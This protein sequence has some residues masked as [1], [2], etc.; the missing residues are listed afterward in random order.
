MPSAAIKTAIQCRKE[1]EGK[2]QALDYSVKQA[3]CKKAG[4]KATGGDGELV[5]RLMAL[6]DAETVVEAESLRQQL[7]EVLVALEAKTNE[8]EKLYQLQ[9]DTRVALEAKTKEAEK[10][11]QRLT[12]VRAAL[13]AN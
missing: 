6:H 12:N 3:R 4:L 13:E 7:T 5:V 9:T 1:H 8:A 10:L 11:D 2:I